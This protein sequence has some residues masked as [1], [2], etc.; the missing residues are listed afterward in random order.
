MKEKL[1][2]ETGKEEGKGRRRG[3]PKGTEKRREGR[4]KRI[5]CKEKGKKERVKYIDGILV[6][7]ERMDDGIR[8]NIPN[9]DEFIFT[10]SG[11]KLFIR[12]NSN[13]ENRTSMAT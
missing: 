7:R 9:L 12:G 1:G 8:S 2:K 10:S 11:Q 3:S 13:R 4:K 5:L 6:T